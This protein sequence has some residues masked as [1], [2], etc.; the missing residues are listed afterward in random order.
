M[1]VQA[2]YSLNDFFIPDD[3]I[4]KN[5]Q[6]IPDMPIHIVHGKKDLLCNWTFAESLHQQLAGSQLHLE[7]GGHSARDFEEKI[8][9]ILTEWEG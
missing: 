4:L 1:R 7:K 9:L 8:K 2:H 3:Y 5:A 6:S